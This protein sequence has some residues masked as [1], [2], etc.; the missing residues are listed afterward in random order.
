[1]GEFPPEAG[2]IVVLGTDGLFD[3]L[4][5]EDIGQIVAEERE[6]LWEDSGLLAR[7]ARDPAVERDLAPRVA[8]ALAVE[9]ATLSQDRHYESPFALARADAKKDSLLSMFPDIN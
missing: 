2:D 8:M 7:L 6:Q 4:F 1:M 9:A 3:N 5:D